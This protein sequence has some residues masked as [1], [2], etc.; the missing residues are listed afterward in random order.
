[1]NGKDYPRYFFHQVSDDIRELFCRTCR[2]LGIDY[3]LN[4]PTEVSIARRRSVARM[5]EFIG[6]KT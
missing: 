6:P 1:M 5:D 4:R 3:T 2:E